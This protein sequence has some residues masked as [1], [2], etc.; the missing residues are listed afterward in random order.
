MPLFK[1]GALA[2]TRDLF[3]QVDDEKTQ[4]KRSRLD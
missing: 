2:S 1:T 3:V 4:K